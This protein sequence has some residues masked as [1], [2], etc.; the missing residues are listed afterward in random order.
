MDQALART[1]SADDRLAVSVDEAADKLDMGPSTI[2][3]YIAEGRIKSVR[4]GG[5][6]LITFEELRRILSVGI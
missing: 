1:K 6:R 2:W 3:K 4:V 5:R